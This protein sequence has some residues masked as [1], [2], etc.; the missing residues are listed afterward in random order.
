MSMHIQDW[1]YNEDG[2][3]AA[4]YMLTVDKKLKSIVS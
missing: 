2:Y 4:A 1:L 3:Q